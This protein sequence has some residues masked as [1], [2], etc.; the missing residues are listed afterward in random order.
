MSR[1]VLRIA[2]ALLTLSAATA[3]AQ[4]TTWTRSYWKVYNTAN[5]PDFQT[6]IDGGRVNGLVQSSLSAGFTPVRT[7]FAAT[8][9]TGSGS[10][11][12]VNGGGE[13]NWWSVGTDRVADGS[14]TSIAFG[15]IHQP[16]NFFPTGHGNNS[17]AFRTARWSGTWT[18]LAPTLFSGSLEA[19]DDAWLFINGQLVLD[20]GGVKAMGHPTTVSN[21]L[22]NAGSNRIDLFFAD[23]NTVQ[24]GIK[25]TQNFTTVPEP[26]TYA[27]LGTG[28]AVLVGVARR[29]RQA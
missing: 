27:L 4:P 6:G 15:D 17:Q 5:N 29:R 11:S 13:L 8:R 23:R 20:N 19:D 7:A 9:A 12:Q 16:S 26:S 24:S 2:L 21:F 28:F 3:Q 22:V 18:A 14:P 25:F 10:I 1:P